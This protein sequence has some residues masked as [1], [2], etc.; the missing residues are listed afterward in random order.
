MARAHVADGTRIDIIVGAEDDV[1]PPALSE[2]YRA[3]VARLG[4]RVGLTE[5]PGKGH[6]ILLDPAV[7]RAVAPLLH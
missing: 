4:K 6:E 2:E 7:L 1:A 5:L 3:A